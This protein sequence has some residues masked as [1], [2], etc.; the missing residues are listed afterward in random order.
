M[1]YLITVLCFLKIYTLQ[2]S[3]RLSVW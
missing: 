3:R 2:E 1:F